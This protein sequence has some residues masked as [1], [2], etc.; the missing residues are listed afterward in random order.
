[1]EERDNPPG[2]H[3]LWIHIVQIPSLA[4]LFFM[5]GFVVSLEPENRQ[6]PEA[7]QLIEAA[8]RGHI[9]QVKDLLRK[10]IYVDSLHDLK[11]V[12]ALY[13][14]AA[15]GHFDIARLL[16]AE[17]AL[18]NFFSKSACDTS[19]LSSIR[20]KN[21]KM[22]KLLIEKGADFQRSYEDGSCK[23][24]LPITTASLYGNYEAVEY[25]LHKGA[26]LREESGQYQLLPIQAAVFGGHKKVLELIVKNDPQGIEVSQSRGAS[27][28]TAA[29][30]SNQFGI[31]QFLLQ[32]GS[33]LQDLKEQRDLRTPASINQRLLEKEF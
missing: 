18:P 12:N 13:V 23:T 25:L 7:T 6:L 8:Q 29:E 9:D 17:G 5:L 26:E 32:N 28:L 27:L 22:T 30:I 31:F 15:K 16:L 24:L 21:F 19:L 10:G 1:M 11:E 2:P 3:W 14:V 4:S 33:R 20:N